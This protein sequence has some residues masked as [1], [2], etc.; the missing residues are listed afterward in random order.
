VPGIRLVAVIVLLTTAATREALRITAFSFDDIWLHLRTGVWILQNHAAPHTGLFSQ[1]PNSQWIAFSWLYDALFASA[2]AALG[3]RAVPLSLMILKVIIAAVTLLLAASQRRGFWSAVVLSGL[4]QLTLY[5][6]QPLPFVF[7]IC[8]FGLATY[9]LFECRS[10]NELRPL[11][12]LPALF[13][14]WANLDAQFVLGLLL[15]ST[16]LIAEVVERT[17]VATNV[18]S[19]GSRRIPFGQLSAISAAC[20]IATFVTPYSIHLIPEAAKFAYSKQLFDNF[21][22]M[23]AMDFRRPEHFLLL[24]LFLAACVGL[25][26]R[27]S[28]D[29]FKIL[30]LAL[31]AALAFRIQRDSWIVVLPS[32]AILAEAIGNRAS[33]NPAA[34]PA[35]APKQKIWIAIMA[36]TVL[37]ISF[38]C[39]PANPVLQ[40][41]LR[42]VLPA[43]A[44][45]YIRDNHLPSPIFNEYQWGGYLTMHLPEY[46]VSID[47]RLN[48]YGVQTS[49]SYFRVAMGKQRMETLPSFASAQTI[50]LPA[51]AAMARALTTI[52]SLQEQFREVYRDDIAVVLVR[53]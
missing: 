10:R 17:L 23:A 37:M 20:V 29:L 27:R 1:L 3:L 21:S 36:A 25:G 53:R 40:L 4:A 47:E 12:W 9:S 49:E 31:C 30:L 19:S 14:L 6:L 16:F 44:C 46:P 15:L 33:T 45:D 39:L 48:L 42:R 34:R 51:N 43:E 18:R 41:R 5:D 50:L 52:P 11:L 28:S 32:I 35:T 2:Y 24:S 13:W 38:L 8:F 7:S 22:M 26:R